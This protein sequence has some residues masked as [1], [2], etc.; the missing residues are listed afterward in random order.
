MY[1]LKAKAQV[2][3]SMCDQSIRL[4]QNYTRVQLPVFQFPLTVAIFRPNEL[5]SSL[6]ILQPQIYILQ[7][8]I[9]FKFIYKHLQWKLSGK[10]FPRSK[11]TRLL[12]SNAAIV[13]S[14]GVLLWGRKTRADQQTLNLSNQ[15]QFYLNQK[16][17]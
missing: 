14:A 5:L 9:H 11:T 15:F 16:I 13:C 8:K 17:Y 3:P 12:V 1:M 7:E 2:W 4:R 6:N 10:I